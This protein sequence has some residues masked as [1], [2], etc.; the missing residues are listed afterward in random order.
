[1]NHNTQAELVAYLQRQPMKTEKEICR[2]LWK[3]V[4]GKKHAD[5]IRRALF[6]KKIARVKMRIPDRE[7]GRA[8]LYYF[9]NV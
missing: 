4:R 2:E 6:S 7:N 9:V 5:L 8:L 1:M 3:S